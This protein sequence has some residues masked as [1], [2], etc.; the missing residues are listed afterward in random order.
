M[1][2]GCQPRQLAWLQYLNLVLRKKKPKFIT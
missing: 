1:A 2:R